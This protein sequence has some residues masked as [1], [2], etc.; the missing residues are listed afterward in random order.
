MMQ[1]RVRHSYFTCT[2]I[3]IAYTSPTYWHYR[4]CLHD[5]KVMQTRRHIMVQPR[6]RN[7][8]M[9]PRRHTTDI[10]KRF[11]FACQCSYGWPFEYQ[12]YPA[13][14][15]CSPR[16]VHHGQALDLSRSVDNYRHLLANAIVCYSDIFDI[17]R[18]CPCCIIYIA[19]VDG[20]SVSIIGCVHC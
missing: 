10:T 3:P 5:A 1:L 16:F 14:T 12:W 6:R 18:V 13:M 17:R 7:T 19:L 4:W 2:S 20:R 9:Q 11:G 8:M 15:G